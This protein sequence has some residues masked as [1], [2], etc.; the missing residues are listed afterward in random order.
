KSTYYPVQ[1][2][3]AA[4]ERMGVVVWTALIGGAIDISLDLA[5]VPRFG[6]LGAAIANGSAQLYAAA[7]LWFRASRTWR[8]D[9]DLR[10]IGRIFL[11]GVVMGAAIAPLAIWLR[12]ILAVPLGIP[13]GAAIYFVML[14]L[15]SVLTEA[16]VLRLRHS[17]PAVSRSRPLNWVM[18]FLRPGQ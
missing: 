9:Y 17:W 4:S 18:E 6:A 13:A 1:V 11:C 16:D 2:L 7:W 3:Y 14:R 15:T 8:L 12:P 5:L 10:T